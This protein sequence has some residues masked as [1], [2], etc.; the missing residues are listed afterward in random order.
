MSERRLVVLG[1]ASQ[2]PT[3]TRN[4]GG[5]LLRWDEQGFLFDPGEGIQQQ[6]I[7]AGLSASEITKIFITHFHGDHCLGLA[8]IV[9]RLSLDAVENTV[10]VYFPASGKAFYESLCNSTIYYHGVK[11]EAHPIATEGKIFEDEHLEITTRPLDHTVDTWGYRIQEKDTFTLLPQRL[12]RLGIH[13][14][15]AGLLKKHGHIDSK[16]QRITIEEAGVKRKGQGFAFVMD[17]RVCKNAS[18]LAE[19]ADMALI[20]STYLSDR[21]ASASA[22]KHLTAAQAAKIA[23]DAGVKQLILSH[24]SQIY[25]QTKAFEQEA[26][27]IFKG[28]RAAKEMD[29]I[30]VKKRQRIRG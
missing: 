17:T 12:E 6:M 3:R 14:R 21:E 28:A 27:A 20:E 2:V 29:S 1:T 11:L 9:Q 22:H 8:G 26:G 13:G 30:P 16:G 23:R 7:H 25:P 4:Q 15:D 5:Y 18:I 10:E 24:F 19:N